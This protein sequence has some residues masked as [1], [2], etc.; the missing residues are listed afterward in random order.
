L[1]PGGEPTPAEL[2]EYMGYAVEGRRRVKEQMN[3]RKADEEFG[4]INLSYFDERNQEVVVFCPE[5]RNAAATQNPQ[6]KSLAGAATR[7]EVSVPVS[8]ASKADAPAAP[9]A[10]TVEAEPAAPP[11]NEVPISEIIRSGESST[12]E[13]KSSLRVNLHTKNPDQKIEHTVLKTLAAFLNTHGG[14]LVIG[15][16]DKGTPLGLESDG[17]LNEDKMDQH[18]ANLIR[19]RLGAHH[20]FCLHPRF[21]DYEGK[22]VLV[23]RCD[24]AKSPAYIKGGKAE[25]FYIRTSGTTTELPASK[26]HDYIKQRFGG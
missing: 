15:V 10:P 18:L 14:T 26:I 2:S 21:T 11:A 19:D 1:H 20:T 6:R 25:Y 16:D 8:P 13:F 3:K 23:V 5:S 4:L 12:V 7:S 24:P 22:R 17:F 9:S